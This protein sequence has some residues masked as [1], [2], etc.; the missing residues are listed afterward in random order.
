MSNTKTNKI[1]VAFASLPTL[2]AP[3]IPV[4]VQKE[5]S[6]KK[7]VSYGNDNRYPDYLLSLYEGCST[8]KAIIDGNV[9]YVMG[10]DMQVAPS[11]ME[12]IKVSETVRECARDW[13]ISVLFMAFNFRSGAASF[14]STSQIDATT[15][16]SMVQTQ[17]VMN[18]GKMEAVKRTEIQALL[19]GEVQVIAIDNNGIAWLLGKDTPVVP[20]GSQNGQTGAA[21]TEANQYSITLQDDAAELPYPFKDDTV[22]AGV[23]TEVV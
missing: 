2:Q 21:K 23:I 13:Y 1:Q 17:L 6:G 14:T 8:L 5:N 19:T 15:G 11:P 22:Y 12:P 18:F 20:V 4:P 3:A 7:Y 10:D 16:V 9:N